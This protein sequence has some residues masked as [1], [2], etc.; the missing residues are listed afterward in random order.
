MKP[1]LVLAALMPRD[2]IARARDEFDAVV[3]P[4]PADM[5]ADEVIAAATAHR[6]DA[7]QFVNT[8]P[9]TAEAIARLPDSVRVGA[10]SS[11]GYDHIDVAAPR[12]A[13][14]W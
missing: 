8:L 9:L 4:G 5:T 13:A 10:T 7:I 11:V 1:R 2:V 3:A 12:R 14:W 6:A